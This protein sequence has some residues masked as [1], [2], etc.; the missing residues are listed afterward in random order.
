LFSAGIEIYKIDTCSDALQIT[1]AA[2][3]DCSGVTPAGS[4]AKLS[5]QNDPL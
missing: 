4:S 2:A 1:A 5:R 3:D